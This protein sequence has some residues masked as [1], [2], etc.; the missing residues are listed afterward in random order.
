MVFT[1]ESLLYL[2][3]D[4]SM[5]SHSLM[6]VRHVPES[7]QCQLSNGTSHVLLI[8]VP[9]KL[10][11]AMG[12]VFTSKFLL[13]LKTNISTLSHSLMPVRNVPES[14]QCQ[15]SNG[16]SHVLLASVPGE[17]QAAMKMVFTSESLLT[18]KADISTLS[19]SIMPVRYVPE[20]S[21]CQPSNGA[22]HNML[23]LLSAELQAA[24]EL[25]FTS[26]F[27]LTLKTDISKPRCS[28]MPIRHVPESPRCQLSN[29]TS[30][31]LLA[32][33]PGKL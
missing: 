16:I 10:Q 19:Y 18:L 17:I 31:I 22:S 15:L 14:P 7:P 24:M 30:H 23:A 28:P 27:L 3:T 6:H 9:T 4:I 8:S 11:A 1:S 32:S 13:T 20:F 12:M 2:K 29:A 33:V 25:A 26:E 5:I 21:R